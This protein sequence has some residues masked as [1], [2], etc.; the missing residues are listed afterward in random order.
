[1]ATPDNID[2]LLALVRDGT[3]F[4]AIERIVLEPD[5]EHAAAAFAKLAQHFYSVEKKLSASVAIRRAGIQFCLCY[6]ADPTKRPVLRARAKAMAFNLGAATWPGWGEDGIVIT[7]ADLHAGLDAARLNLRLAR[8]LEKGP[9]AESR[10]HWLVGAHHLARAEDDA[11]LAEFTRAR[12]RARDAN[13]VDNELLNAGYAALVGTLRGNTEA[14]AELTGVVARLRG[15]PGN[16]GPFFAEQIEKA[17]EIFRAA[18][19]PRS[20]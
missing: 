17:L 5:P 4:A 2:E 20:A 15:A 8:E 12:E 7:T 19:A 10:G 11:A 6:T 14:N 3:S 9:L 1:M 18:R 16:E 13:D